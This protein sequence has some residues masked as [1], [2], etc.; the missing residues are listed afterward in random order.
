MP[1]AYSLDLRERVLNACDQGASA[2]QVAVH[3]TVSE[4]FIDKLKRRRRESGTLAPK[5]H[6]GGR[7]PLLAD[8]SETLRAQLQ[9][10]PDT[11]LAELRDALVQ[12]VALS[13]LWY[14]LDRLGLTFKKKPCVP[15]NRRART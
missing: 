4:S 14:H 10:K 9:A 5:P 12:P 3:Y 6:A 7:Q 8:Q 13:T 1:K 15:P 2:A 11:T